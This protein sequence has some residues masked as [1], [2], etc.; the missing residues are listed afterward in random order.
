MSMWQLS[1][2]ELL[3]RA[4]SVRHLVLI[5]LEASVSGQNMSFWGLWNSTLKSKSL[6]STFF[7][8][9]EKPQKADRA[10]AVTG[11]SPVHI[12]LCSQETH[13]GRYQ[14]PLH[15]SHAVSQAA[16]K[17]QFL[18]K[19]IHVLVE[20]RLITFFF[21]RACYFELPCIYLYIF[22]MPS[23]RFVSIYWFTEIQKGE[24]YCN[25]QVLLAIWTGLVHD[26]I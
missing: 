12:M 5:R 9:S 20:C 2:L 4:Y 19:W 10:Q 24:A 13:S 8:V 25:T 3:K 21:L 6:F 15:F 1:L 17:Q 11:T 14:V 23:W 22:E 16:C 18:T 7:Q 26:K